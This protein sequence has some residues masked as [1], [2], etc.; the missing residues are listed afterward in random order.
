M[1]TASLIITVV[2][3]LCAPGL[4]L[5][6]TAPTASPHEPLQKTIGATAKTEVV[7][8]LIV[9]N[10]RGVSLQGNKLVLTGWHLTLSFLPTGRFVLLG[11]TPQ[12]ILLMIGRP[13]ATTLRKILRTQ[14]CPRS[15]RMVLQSVMPWSC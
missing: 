1:R 7:P 4:A 15:A 12:A 13:A 6:Q 9:L 10:S 14:P 2:A 5:A 11:T 8:S 3:L